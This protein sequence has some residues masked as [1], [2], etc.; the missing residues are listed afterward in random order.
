MK[1]REFITARRA[2]SRAASV[3]ILSSCASI[4]GRRRGSYQEKR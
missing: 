4:F 3:L 2:L 1:R